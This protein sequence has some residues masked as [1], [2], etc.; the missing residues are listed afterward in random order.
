M[1]KSTKNVINFFRSKLSYV[2]L[3]LCI[4]A[5]GASVTL[6]IVLGNGKTV[7]EGGNDVEVIEPVP[8]VPENPDEPEDPT[9]DEPTSTVV[10]FIM[11]VS[12][13]TSIS[14]YNEQMVFNP[15]L[16][17]YSVH[18]AIDFFAEEGTKVFA[19]WGGTVESVENDL[20][21]GITVTL[22]HGNGLKTVYNSLADVDS[23]T[24]GQTVSK[25]DV[26]GEVSVTN[27]QEQVSGAHLH[28]EVYENGGIIDPAKYLTIDE[29]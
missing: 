21:R 10:T 16:D 11:P 23:V 18:T 28:F 22:D 25:G 5:I 12:E 3:A 15:T 19:V 1:S 24:V 4:I 9:P 17:R 6:A 20:L 2:V 27:R 14:H 8:D 29:K 26:I 13:P 7:T